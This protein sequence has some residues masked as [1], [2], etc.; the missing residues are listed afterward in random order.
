M[1][2]T[3]QIGAWAVAMTVAARTGIG[4]S[5]QKPAEATEP[6]QA[7]S[8][9][10]SSC[11]R[12]YRDALKFEQ[13]AQLVKAKKLLRSCAKPKCGVFLQHQCTY[14]FAQIDA[15]MPSVVPLVTD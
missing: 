11:D 13:S 14:H 15:E 8:G 3:L 1:R 6:Q 9:G 7:E 10:H 12:A 5:A 2:R 4:Q